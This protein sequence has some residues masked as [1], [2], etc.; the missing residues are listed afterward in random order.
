MK[1]KKKIDFWQ[2][3]PNVRNQSNFKGRYDQA[4]ED[5]TFM[6]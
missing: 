6:K 3:S 1:K 4:S 2:I 5:L